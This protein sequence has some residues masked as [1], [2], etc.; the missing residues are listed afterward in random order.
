MF[1]F[2][3]GTCGLQKF[4]EHENTTIYPATQQLEK[5]SLTWAYPI[6]YR[7]VLNIIYKWTLFEKHLL[8]ISSE[9]IQLVMVPL[10]A[11]FLLLKSAS[12]SQ[13]FVCEESILPNWS[14]AQMLIDLFVAS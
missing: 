13:Q 9:K 2:I 5:Q 10:T 12:N 6:F 7:C 8:S 11:N 14:S 4:I 1:W 3:I